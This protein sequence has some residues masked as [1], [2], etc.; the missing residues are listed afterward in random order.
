MDVSHL[1]IH[2][3]EMQLSFM[4]VGYVILCCG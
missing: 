1:K 4:H 3:A 2:W